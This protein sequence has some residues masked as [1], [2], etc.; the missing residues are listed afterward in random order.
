MSLPNLA[1]LITALGNDLSRNL[2]RNHSSFAETRAR[3]PE[4]APFE[5]LGDIR[6]ALEPSSSLTVN[7]RRALVTALVEESQKGVSVIWSS[8]LVLAFAPM[9][10]RLR[11]HVGPRFDPDL[12]SEILV[13]FLSAV[14]TVRPGSYTSLALRWA[15]EKEV[16]N[17]RRAERRLGT[18]APFDEDLHSSP[19]LHESES[20]TTFE[21]ILRTLEK[22]GAAEILDVL[23][24]TRGRDESLRAYVV[25]TC[26]NPRERNARYEHLCR[27]R[28]T[29]EREIRER[30]TSKAA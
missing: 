13:A 30:I 12:D 20:R 10:H 8:L 21:E 25:R 9:M 24:A 23:I 29:L 3:R 7:A 22:E 19:V 18:L 5:T 17:A 1:I 11:K 6:R 28:L 14:R 26:P 4:L 16:L 2:P 27:A 15:T